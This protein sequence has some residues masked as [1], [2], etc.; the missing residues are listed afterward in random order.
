MKIQS[1]PRRGIVGGIGLG[2]LLVLMLSGSALSPAL[3]SAAPPVNT[4]PPT[5]LESTPHVGTIN[6][7]QRGSWSSPGEPITFTYQWLRCNSGGSGCTEI[8]GATEIFYTP[9]EADAVHTLE[10]R[11]KATNASGETIAT[12]KPTNVLT[13]A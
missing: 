9:V 8:A 11:V 3:A 7:A 6:Y 13:A 1:K 4:S 2:V 10:F 12:S 5:I